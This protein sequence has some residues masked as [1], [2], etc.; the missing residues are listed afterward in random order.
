MAKHNKTINHLMIALAALQDGDVEEAQEALTD[1]VSEDDFDDALEVLDEVQESTFDEEAS[2]EEEGVEPDLAEEEIADALAEE[3]GV[4]VETTAGALTIT[5]AGVR[6]AR[7]AVR[8]I[9][10]LASVEDA[11]EIEE[12][13][14]PEEIEGEFAHVIRASIE[15]EDVL[16]GVNDDGSAEVMAI[17]EEDEDVEAGGKKGSGPKFGGGKGDYPQSK[18]KAGGRKGP[19]SHAS[20]DEDFD[21]WDE[22]ET[23]EENEEDLAP[24]ASIRRNR[25]V[26]RRRA[27]VAGLNFDIIARNKRSV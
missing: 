13:E 7:R 11:E 15:G 1:A 26:A 21:S 23:D 12:D 27:T 5:M 22:E 9:K 3:E 18:S 16:I 2:D 8:V 10:S 4:E 25:Q 20:T 14:V 19:K 17:E 6:N 24:T